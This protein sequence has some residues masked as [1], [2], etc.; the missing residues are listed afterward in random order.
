MLFKVSFPV[1]AAY[2]AISLK[3]DVADGEK[4]VCALERHSPE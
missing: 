2:V 3:M 4:S 1:T